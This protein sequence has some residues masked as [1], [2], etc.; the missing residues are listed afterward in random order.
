MKLILVNLTKHVVN[1]VMKFYFA[2]IHY[3]PRFFQKMLRF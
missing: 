1:N 3:N 2:E